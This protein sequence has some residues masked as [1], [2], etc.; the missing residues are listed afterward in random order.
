MNNP[1]VS[2]IVPCRNEE[3]FIAACLD[4]LI[5]QSYPTEQSQIIVIDGA[6]TDNTTTIIKEYA[7]RFPK[8]ITVLNNEK[9]YKPYALNIGIRNAHG[10]IVMI[11]DAHATYSKDYLETCLNAMERYHADVVGGR[12]KAT[13]MVAAIQ[14]RA[15]TTTFSHLLGIGNAMYQIGSSTP[16]FVDAVFGGCYRRE[17]FDEV[18]LFNENL[19][20]S[21]DMEMFVRLRKAGKKILLVP[22]V[23]C[24]YYPKQTI[25]DFFYHNVQDG[26]WAIYPLK[27]VRVPLRLRHYV[28]LFFM[29]GLAAIGIIGIFLPLASTLFWSMLILYATIVG[30]SA[31][32]LAREK[33]DLMLSPFLVAAFVARHF[34]YGIGSVIG[35][36]KLVQPKDPQ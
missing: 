32:E 8:L 14:A 20:R 9:R 3:R 27:F 36:M 18:G 33:N 7:H 15:I 17:L 31:V 12:R 26:I 6:S 21:Q 11:A 19:I 30:L 16:Q 25:K 34:G 2:I 10:S 29:L 5:F 22:D 28:P 1:I 24:T 13:P 35:L 23:E 4:S